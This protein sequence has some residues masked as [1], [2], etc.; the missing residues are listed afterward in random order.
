[1][2]IFFPFGFWIDKAIHI[3][4][5][6]SADISNAQGKR[7]IAGPV[8]SVVDHCIPNNEHQSVRNRFKPSLLRVVGREHSDCRHHACQMAR[9]KSVVSR[10]AILKFL[11][12]WE[13][14]P[15]TAWFC[16]NARAF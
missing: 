9:G 12:T 15:Y 11:K 8:Y 13:R 10:S 2:L 3:Y 6:F 5:S 7:I 16:A 14:P 1:M 4:G